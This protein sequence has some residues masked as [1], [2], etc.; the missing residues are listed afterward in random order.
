MGQGG[1]GE[2]GV[3][4]RKPSLFLGE[5]GCGCVDG[6]AASLRIDHRPSALSSVTQ[7]QAVNFTHAS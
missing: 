2:P 7:D 3:G 1:H 5:Q 6:L 4:N